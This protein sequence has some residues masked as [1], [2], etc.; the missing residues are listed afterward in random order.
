MTAFETGLRNAE[1][2]INHIELP[3][4][5]LPTVLQQAVL[6]QNAIGWQ[7]VWC[8]FVSN[9]WAEAA[10]Y[11]EEPFKPLTLQSWSLQFY[12]A[13]I[14][15][16]MNMW[17]DRNEIHHG[18]PGEQQE[19]RID[20]ELLSEISHYYSLFCQINTYYPHM[21]TYSLDEWHSKSRPA[22]YSWLA[23]ARALL[24]HA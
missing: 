23:L 18:P 1:H 11:L 2:H 10:V 22:K 24:R 15:Y 7:N 12:V 8:G 3:P 16:I 4:P 13:I 17:A 20:E 9:K 5:S 14:N 19:K 21:T 6:E